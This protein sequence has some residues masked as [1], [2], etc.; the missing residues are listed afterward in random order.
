L[1]N[2]S[3]LFSPLRSKPKAAQKSH[4]RFL[5]VALHIV[6]RDDDYYDRKTLSRIQY[7]KIQIVFECKNGE[8]TLK[9][10]RAMH[11]IR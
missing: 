4:A 8:S 9:S 1:R 2:I 11:V 3:L 10:T 7:Q 6:R 5:G